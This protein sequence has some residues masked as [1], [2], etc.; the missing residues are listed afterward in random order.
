MIKFLKQAPLWL[1]VCLV[2]LNNCWAYAGFD[3]KVFQYSHLLV[4]AF[5]MYV[6]IK[7]Q[8]RR[9]IPPGTHKVW[10]IFLMLTP[11]LSSYSSYV[12]L[13]RG[14]AD[15]LVVYRM[16][17]GYLL[18]FVLWYK[19]VTEK[20][21]IAVIAVIGI[22][23]ALLTIGQQFTYPFAPF[24]G[25]TLGSAYAE[26][27]SGGVERRLGFYRF[28]V[29]GV[30]YAVILAV[31]YFTVKLPFP[32]WVVV[33]LLASIV[34]SGNRQTIGITAVALGLCHVLTNRASKKI[35]YLLLAVM[36][37]AVVYVYRVEIFGNLANWNTDLQE[38][39][40]HSYIYFW[41]LSTSN[42]LAFIMGYGLSRVGDGSID[43]S[44]YFVDGK[45]VVVSDIGIVG[46]LHYWGAVYA[47]SLIG[48]LASLSFSKLLNGA[49][50]AISVGI[51]LFIWVFFMSWEINGA[52]FI[53]LFTYAC[54]L[55]IYKNRM[56]QIESKSNNH[57]GHV[58][59]LDTGGGNSVGIA[60]DVDGY[61][62]AA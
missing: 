14:V 9:R 5:F 38:G 34:A 41:N 17:L 62:E 51:L 6:I 54:D 25:R 20:Q 2:L 43:V 4:L 48:L 47:I 52:A 45:P 33:L 10:L 31:L 12:L 44:Q 35:L 53:A 46:C 13:H 21:L 1:V 55:N 19:R 42:P 40:A 15:S 18:Y 59:K 56:K 30:M 22:G 58:Y 50:R 37:F 49:Y 61:Q 3:L 8:N 57:R 39:R 36:V 26:H 23:Y 60:H 7:E 32:K 16:H 29:A 28:A 24:G 27:L 11:L